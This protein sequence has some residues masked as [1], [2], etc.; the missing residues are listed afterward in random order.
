M[1]VVLLL[2][3]K[4]SVGALI[5]AIGLG[6]T[7]SDIAYL[8][9]RPRLLLRAL[10]AMYVLVP[11][12]AIIMV[13]LWPLAPGVKAALLV[14]AVSAGAPLLPR[15][16]GKV[17]GGTFTVSLVVITSLAA[18]VVVPP[19]IN[20]LARHFDAA[21][22]IS[23]LDIALMIVKAFL[24]PLAV[25]MGL[26]AFF[27]RL[28]GRFADRLAALAGLLL[29]TASLGLLAM[30]WS[31]L[32]QVQWSGLLALAVLLLIAM[33]IGHFLGGPEESDRT[34]LAIACATRHIG[35]AVVVVAMFPGPRTI[36]VLA[37]Y[38]AVSAL[39]S[40]PYLKWRRGSSRQSTP[41]RT[42]A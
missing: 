29:V 9:R 22:E 14:L 15:K 17:G 3:V 4:V 31:L 40:L 24:L 37:A 26:G 13:K 2:L 7:L 28:V 1:T 21:I 39:V 33:A 20:L 19:W 6:A 34:A 41:A 25:G 8:W 23:T 27:P 38:V 30:N 5:L 42:G 12:A 36:V 16:L 11:L 18:I 35:I 32:L 10:L